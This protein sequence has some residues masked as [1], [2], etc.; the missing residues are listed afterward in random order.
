[1]LLLLRQA[2][3]LQ[4]RRHLRRPP[5]C[6][7]GVLEVLLNLRVRGLETAVGCDNSV[8][9]ETI[10]NAVRTIELGEAV[11]HPPTAAAAHVS[12]RVVAK[13]GKGVH[14]ANA[15]LGRP[16]RRSHHALQLPSRPTDLLLHHQGRPQVGPAQSSAG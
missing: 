13:V 8:A 1:M 6:C 14:A 15:V 9:T 5:L 10:A 11:L 7:R 3:S 12:E 2:L 4:L 16:R